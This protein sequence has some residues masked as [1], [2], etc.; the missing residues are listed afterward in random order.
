MMKAKTSPKEQ[1]K[2]LWNWISML[3]VFPSE[4]LEGRLRDSFWQGHLEGEFN[5]LSDQIDEEN[6]V[7]GLNKLAD[8]SRRQNHLRKLKG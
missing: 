8:F 5:Q 1:A 7:A 4:S 3:S 2:R 6:L